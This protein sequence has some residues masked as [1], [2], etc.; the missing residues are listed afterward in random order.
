MSDNNGYN[1]F[2]MAQAEFDRVAKGIGLDSGAV[3]LL[4]N[5]MREYQ[6]SIPVRLDDGT[7]Q[8]FRGFRV[9]HNDACGP[10]KG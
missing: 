10:C 6:F 1:P 4:R 5:P 9:Q 7:T 8:V 2:A 3:E